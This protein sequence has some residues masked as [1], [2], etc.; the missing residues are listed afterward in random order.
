MIYLLKNCVVLD[1]KIG[2]TQCMDFSYC[3]WNHL[4]RSLDECM[5]LS[6]FYEE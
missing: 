5:I 1:M 2:F 3:M 4:F 6:Q